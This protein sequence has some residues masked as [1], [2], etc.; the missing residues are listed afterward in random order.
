MI[1]KIINIKTLIILVNNVFVYRAYEE[2]IMD[3]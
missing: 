2:P 1:S 3:S